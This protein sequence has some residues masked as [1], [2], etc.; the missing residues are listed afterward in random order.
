M[1]ATLHPYLTAGVALV[2]ASMIAVT[3]V[4]APLV[5]EVQQRAVELTAAPVINDPSTDWLEI[6]TK[7]L[8]NVGQIGTAWAEHPFP[9]L[10]QVIDNQIGYAETIGGALQGS[11]TGLAAYF[12]GD[13]PTALGSTLQTVITDL[14]GGDAVSA[15]NA[16]NASV[17]ALAQGAGFPLLD[18]LK[19][20]IDITSNISSALQTFAFQVQ[21][22]G[23]G[24][25]SAM[26][27]GT[28]SLGLSAQAIIDAV[29]QSDPLAAFGALAGAPAAFTDAVLNGITKE[30]LGHTSYAYLGLLSPTI[31][32][33]AQS[34]GT[35]LFVTLPQAIAAAIAPE[36]ASAASLAAVDLAG[37]DLPSLLGGFT[38]AF[39]GAL[40]NLGDL[41]DP[42][43]LFAE[44]G[45]VVPGV[46]AE[47]PQMLLEAATAAIPF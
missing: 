37:V 24:A 27:A 34:V 20:P 18:M 23:I 22:I 9:I 2:G 10:Q 43:Q 4:A 6:F 21:G 32:Q 19:V 8:G 28:Y 33:F 31:G 5:T 11:V 14:M 35:G 7:A 38:Q 26:G 39:E 45:T 29:G 30:F 1:H 12:T 41:F 3:P 46:F 44:L 25:L 15:A 17:M 40:G 36:D 42:A 16:I 13:A 47:I